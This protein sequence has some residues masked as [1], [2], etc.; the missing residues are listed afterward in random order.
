M[1]SVLNLKSVDTVVD[2]G[3]GFGS[4]G[5][6]LHKH[7]E[8]SHFVGVE[9]VRARGVEGMRIF[10]Q[11]GASHVKMMVTDAANPEFQLPSAQVYFIM[12]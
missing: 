2:L 8:T 10:K 9:I 5:L 7:F 1:L 11:R 4:M 6:V 3:A 12:T